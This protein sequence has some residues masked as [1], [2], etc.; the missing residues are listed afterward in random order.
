[1]WKSLWCFCNSCSC[2]HKFL[3]AISPVY[4]KALHPAANI[5]C[6]ISETGYNNKGW[7]RFNRYSLLVPEGIG[8]AKN[9]NSVASISYDSDRDEDIVPKTKAPTNKPENAQRKRSYRKTPRTVS[10]SE[11]QKVCKY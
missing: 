5:V 10:K 7:S 11:E 2:N 3:S 6:K 8:I 1:M 4:Y 9:V